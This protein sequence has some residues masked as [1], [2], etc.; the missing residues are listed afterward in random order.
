MASL[1]DRNQ[2]IL[3][4]LGLLGGAANQVFGLKQTT[5]EKRSAEPF[6]RASEGVRAGVRKWG[7]EKPNLT[8]VGLTPP[9]LFGGVVPDAGALLSQLVTLRAERVNQPGIQLMTS[10]VRRHGVGPL[11]KKPYSA[12]FNDVT[13]SFIGDA[14][15]IIHQFFYVWMSAIIGFDNMP[16]AGVALDSFYGKPFELSYRD[17]YK[18]T[19]DIVT[20]DEVQQKIGVVKLY[21]AYPMFLGEIQRDWSSVNDLVRIPVTFTYSHWAYDGSLELQLREPS[22]QTLA[23]QNASL[24]DNVMKGASVLQTITSV[25]SPRNVNDVLNVVNSG[26]TLLRSLLPNR[27]NY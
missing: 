7:I 3:G 20:Y 4:T 6:A 12:G 23:S 16:Q 8:Y 9:N 19:I 24:F 1:N 11:E 25:K 27:L 2:Q 17:S 18:T 21:N 15:G 13:V 22:R 10:S 5:S 14:R 26:S